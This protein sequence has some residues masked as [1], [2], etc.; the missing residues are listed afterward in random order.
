MGF[1]S[2]WD[3]GDYSALLNEGFIYK[4]SLTKSFHLPQLSY[5]AFSRTLFPP[6]MFLKMLRMK[7]ICGYKNLGNTRLNIFICFAF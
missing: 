2:Y 4:V 6:N 3:T 1:S 5:L 7:I